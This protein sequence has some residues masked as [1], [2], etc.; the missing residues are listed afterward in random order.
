MLASKLAAF[1]DAVDRSDALRVLTDM[2]G[3]KEAVWARVEPHVQ[4]KAELTKAC[5]AF[6]ELWDEAH[7]DD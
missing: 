7:G 3:D 4:P 2:E 1:R 6:D 5:Y